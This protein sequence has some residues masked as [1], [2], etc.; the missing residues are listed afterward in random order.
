MT[1]MDISQSSLSLAFMAAAQAEEAL[2]AI[3][4]FVPQFFNTRAQVI[5][6]QGPSFAYVRT[7]E[8]NGG[9]PTLYFWDGALLN[10]VSTDEAT[11]IQK[12]LDWAYA[13][14]FGRLVS[15]TH[16]ANSVLLS[17]DIVWPDGTPGE[18]VTDAQDASSGAINAWHA[19]YIGATTKTITQL[20]VT[21]EA[22]GAVTAQPPITVA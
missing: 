12:L 21:R 20:A 3:V 8:T 2:A 16:D 15:G 19:T 18:Y 10:R 11:L 22:S 5:G 13:G 1:T 7:D 4:G 14:N 6:L 9:T 17:A